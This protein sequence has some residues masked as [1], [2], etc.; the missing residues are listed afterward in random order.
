MDIANRYSGHLVFCGGGPKPSTKAGYL[1][2]NR[3]ISTHRAF[4]GGNLAGHD[5]Y[6]AAT[7]SK[8]CVFNGIYISQTFMLLIALDDKSGSNTLNRDAL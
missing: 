3:D 1:V 8:K 2:T 5:R 4:P 6:S 7:I